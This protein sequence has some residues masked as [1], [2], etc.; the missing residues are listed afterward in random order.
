ML[1]PVPPRSIRY[2]HKSPVRRRYFPK[3][4]EAIRHH[5]MNR[6]GIPPSHTGALSDCVHATVLSGFH[7][8]R[9]SRK[10]EYPPPVHLS[11]GCSLAIYNRGYRLLS[12]S[13]LKNHS[14]WHRYPCHLLHCRYQNIHHPQHSLPYLL[15]VPDFQA[16]QH[17]YGLPTLL[18]EA[19][20]VSRPESAG[21]RASV[22]AVAP[23][24]VFDGNLVPYSFLLST[25][26][27]YK[28]NFLTRDYTD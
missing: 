5:P 1:L 3:I 20:T 22:P 27:R 23:E 6:S 16:V 25:V 19:P 13:H 4:C 11:N 18:R 21:A 14:H 24:I 2:R 9:W 8:K 26:S 28:S 15:Q 17:G 12:D 10:M 7:K